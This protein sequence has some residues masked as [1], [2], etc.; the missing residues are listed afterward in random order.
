VPRD[1]NSCLAE[2][3]EASFYDLLGNVAEFAL[4]NG[5][6][7][8]YGGSFQSDAAGLTCQSSVDGQDA[9]PQIGFRCCYTPE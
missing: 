7:K 9:A 2:R 4:D 1:F 3:G 6:G 8:V 5:Q